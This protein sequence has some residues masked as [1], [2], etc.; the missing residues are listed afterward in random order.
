VSQPALVVEHLS[1]RFRIGRAQ[2]KYRTLRESLMD[3][4]LRPLR[5]AAGRDAGPADDELWALRDVSFEVGSGEVMGIVGRNGA[6]KSTLLKI[7][8]R[9]SEPTSGRAIVEGRVGA[10]L[11]VGTGFHPELTGRENILLNG[12]ILGMSRA[13]IRR[14]FDEIVAF[15]EIDR[16]LDTPVKR[17]SSGMYMRLAFSVA[18]HLEPE[19]LIVDEV[20]AVG[21]AAFQRKCLG[22]MGQVAGE[23][24]TV[25]FVSHNLPA[26]TRLCHRAVLLVDGRVAV[27]GPT[28]AV[29]GAYLNSDL[30]TASSREWP[31]VA[32]A[33]GNDVV[34]LRRARVRTA[35]GATAQEIDIRDPV[36]VELEFDVLQPGKVLTPNLHVF[37]QEGVCAFV[38]ID[39]DPEWHHRPRPVGRC[40]STAWLPGNFLNEGAY[41]LGVAIS[42]MDP[43]HAHF[44]E[45]DALSIQVVDTMEGTGARGNYPGPMLG[46]LRPL[47]R[48]ETRLEPSPSLVA[49]GHEAAP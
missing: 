31:D 8:S 47:L 32:T 46:V 44:F 26:V 41:V 3:G 16:F 12:A 17:Y 37:N 2:A 22:K 23:G 19:I 21:D 15:A 36:A 43:V 20:L 25:L 28:A 13:D 4:L 18:A 27:C 1:K 9:I 7:L 34:R 35:D 29:V 30:G 14:R 48:W 33:P 39:S 38:S 5:R 40:V 6:G 49:A 10:L 11:E 45:Q 24:R 42:T